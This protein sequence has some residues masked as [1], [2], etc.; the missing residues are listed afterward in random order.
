MD[1]ILALTETEFFR[2]LRKGLP[3]LFPA[4]LSC[5]SPLSSPAINA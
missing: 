3:A 1:N 2:K 5:A 4:R